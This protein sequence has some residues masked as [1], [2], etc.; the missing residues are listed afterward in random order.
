MGQVLVGSSQ[1]AISGWDILGNSKARQGVCKSA[2]MLQCWGGSMLD[3]SLQVLE[4]RKMHVGVGLGE[5]HSGK[6]AVFMRQ[7][8]VLE[9]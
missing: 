8:A 9:G 5:D 4:S 2:I 6:R 7:R 3:E 1:A